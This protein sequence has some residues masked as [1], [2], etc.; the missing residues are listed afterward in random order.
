LKKVA[1]ILLIALLFFNWYGYRIV[2]TIMSLSADRQLE[3]QIDNNNYDESELIE[4]RVPLNVPYQ[5]DN[6]TFQRYYGEIEVNGKYYT[7]V[8]RKVE[9]GYLVL[10]CI[11]NNSKAKIKAVSNDFFKMANGL[12]QDQ[13]GKKQNTANFAKNFWSEYDDRETNFDIDI[14]SSL[15]KN[16]FPENAASLSDVCLSTPSQPPELSVG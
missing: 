11:S 13:P 8:K 1:A 3:A 10:K 2:I 9:D 4:L 6:A 16:F 12:A 15:F 14:H 7:Y 5:N